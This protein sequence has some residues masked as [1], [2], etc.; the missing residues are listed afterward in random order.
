MI[1][2][3]KAVSAFILAVCILLLQICLP[4]SALGQI[5]VPERLSGSDRYKTAVSISQ[6]GWPDGSDYAVIARGDDFADALCAG[7]LAKK[8]NAPI[9]L[10][11]TDSLGA[12]TLEELKRL[13][14]KN[15]IIVGGTGAVSQNVESTIFTAGIS[16][17]ERI[18]GSD[19]YETSAKIA[20]KVGTSTKVVLATGENFPDALSVSAIAANMGMPILLT[21]KDSLPEGARQYIINNGVTNTY[22]IGGNGVISDGVMYTVPGFKRLGGIDRYETNVLV[23]QEFAG[24]LNFSNIFTAVGDGPNGDEFADALS[25]AVLAAQTASPL[26]LANGVLPA[27]TADFL[28]TRVTGEST[29]TALGGEAVMPVTVIEGLVAV[30]NNAS[31]APVITPT[32]VVT[33]TPTPTPAVTPP[34]GGGGGGGGAPAAQTADITNIKVISY[35][36]ETLLNE[37]GDTF[38][39]SR[40][41][42]NVRIKYIEVTADNNCAIKI[43]GVLYEGDDLWDSEY[44]TT[45]RKNT[46]RRLDIDSILDFTS[47]NNGVL[48]GSLR[49]IVDSVTIRGILE[50]D[51]EEV[52]TVRINLEL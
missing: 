47:G 36:G 33:P 3:R 7:P 16:H 49:S 40:F 42:D 1:K 20:E 29:V 38:D 25:G 44:T 37:D 15:I 39:L 6:K 52:N 28:K 32:P 30:I 51:G 5:R 12:D 4:K 50:I 45:L 34:A 18:W 9:L 26:I 31:Q 22:L 14:V 27:V 8:Y 19:R 13:K 35:D 46:S 43:T 21:M 24:S 41:G 48:L 2:N 10:T 23:M 11:M 17:M